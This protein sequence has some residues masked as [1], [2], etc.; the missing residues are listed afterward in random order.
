MGNEVLCSEFLES[1]EMFVECSL[2]LFTPYAT[3]TLQ[4][5]QTLVY[6]SGETS[7]FIFSSLI[8]Y[9]NVISII[10]ISKVMPCQLFKSNERS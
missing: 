2:V 9:I 10:L 6:N 8:I 7:T 3:R 5:I 4:M 1:L